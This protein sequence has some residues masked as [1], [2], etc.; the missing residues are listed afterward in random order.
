MAKYVAMVHAICYMLEGRN[1]S[2]CFLV[3]LPKSVRDMLNLRIVVPT[4][5]GIA[6]IV[7]SR[8]LLMNGL[9]QRI[10]YIR[11]QN[12]GCVLLAEMWTLRSQNRVGGR[13]AR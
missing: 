3:H 7:Q 9:S 8:D 10:L 2:R 12:W 11:I 5:T 4:E 13:I 1:V 6:T